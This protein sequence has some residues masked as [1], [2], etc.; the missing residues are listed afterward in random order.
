MGDDT[1]CNWVWTC[2]TDSTPTAFLISKSHCGWVVSHSSRVET[3][4]N[5]LNLV[6]SNGFPPPVNGKERSPRPLYHFFDRSA[7]LCLTI[8]TLICCPT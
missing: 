8:H 1:L 6:G 5:G 3:I 4:P 2:Q 7:F